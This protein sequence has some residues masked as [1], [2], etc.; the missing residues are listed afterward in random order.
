MKP[1]FAA[2]L[3]TLTATGSSGGIYPPPTAASLRC[4]ARD[5][6]LPRTMRSWLRRLNVALA[7]LLLAAGWQYSHRATDGDPV[8][9]TPREPLAAGDTIHAPIYPQPKMGEEELS[10]LVERFHPRRLEKHETS[11]APT[12]ETRLPL[13]AF[14]VA[15]ILR[16]PQATVGLVLKSKDPSRTETYILFEGQRHKDAEL[17]SVTL[18][19]RIAHCHVRRGDEE[20]TFRVKLDSEPRSR[21]VRTAIGPRGPVLADRWQRDHR[22]PPAVTHVVP[23]T[24]KGVPFYGARGKVVGFRVSGVKPGSP[25]DVIGVKAGDI[26]ERLNDNQ[27]SDAAALRL[28]LA[29]GVE[30][31]EVVVRRGAGSKSKT[32]TLRGI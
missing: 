10:R 12:G 15:M 32:L 20:F 4:Y 6:M 22:S 28:S 30:P 31:T 13:R 17:S 8:R 11:R 19:G 23:R 18:E 2:F 16:D 5:M 26:I 1:T 24:I 3:S 27:V 29:R 14:R 9:W 21:A 25:F 7:A